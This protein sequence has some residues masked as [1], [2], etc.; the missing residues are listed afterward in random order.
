VA[1]RAHASVRL[2]SPYDGEIFRLALPALG[3]L[4]AEPL[5]ILVD[6]AIVGHLCRSQLA[7]LGVAAA[8]L[9]GVF[10]IFNFLQYGTTAQVARARGAGRTT[11]ADELGVQA[12]WLSGG[13]G[14]VVAAL[15]AALA[16]PLAS[17]IGAEGETR[18]F[19][20][21]YLRIASIG[22]AM[23]FLALGGSGYLRGVAD[24]RSPLLIVIWANVANVV[25]EL[26]FVYGFDWGIAGSAWGTV[27]AQMGMGA[28][29]LVV[30]ARRMEPET[31]RPVL[32]LIRRLLS[33]GKWIFLRTASLTGSF[34]LASAVA[35]RFGDASIGAHQIAF[36]LFF[37]LALVLDSIAI[38][39]QIIIGRELGAGSLDAAYAAGSRMIAL[40]TAVGA[41]FAAA[42]LVS[43]H[44]VPRAFTGDE[45]V[46]AEA[47][48][49]WPLF[50]L[51]QP[52]AGA[53]FALDGILIGAGDG[54]FLAGSMLLAFL[55]C[56]AVLV[57]SLVWDWGMRGVWTALLVLV[58][59]RLTTMWL[60]FRRRR[61]LVTGWT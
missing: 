61:W 42:L 19:A 50:A 21:T 60:R 3:A 27:V 15:V 26:L 45:H 39:G 18:D 32:A 11:T 7:A 52:L 49:L 53:V 57:A 2:R 54:P 46:L 43:A 51:T 33:L 5:Y 38:A 44:V 4:A 34:L 13:F 29:F 23:A 28:A 17:L 9:G 25:L 48:I 41:A 59:V 47:A 31:W 58:W 16:G 30:I 20:V 56:A 37:F 22:L 35:T 36:Q 40:S 1:T 10:A 12:L 8:A 24:L 55:C 14:V 6:T